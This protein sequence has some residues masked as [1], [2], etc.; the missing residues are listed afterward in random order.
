MFFSLVVVVCLLIIIY[1]INFYYIYYYYY[2]LIFFLLSSYSWWWWSMLQSEVAWSP[3][4]KTAGPLL[5]WLNVYHAISS[6]VPYCDRILDT[7]A[8]N[9]QRFFCRWL[10]CSGNQNHIGKC[11]WRR[12]D[13]KKGPS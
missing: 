8:C 12:R 3:G 9:Q 5:L 4:K 10:E 7:A 6:S 1:I 13:G 11:K 2:H